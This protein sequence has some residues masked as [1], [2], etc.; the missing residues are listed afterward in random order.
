LTRVAVVVEQPAFRAGLE[1]M[2]RESGFELAPEEEAEVIISDTLE[3]AA[4][5]DNVAVVLIGDA[6]LLGEALEAGVRGV[7]PGNSTTDEL[8]AV[9]QA[10]AAGLVAFPA[11]NAAALFDARP[12]S[13]MSPADA[14]VL[15]PRELEVLQMMAEGLANKEIAWRMGISEHTV[16]FHVASILNRLDAGSRT[17][18]VSMGLRRGLIM[19]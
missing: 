13:A 16:K 1:S 7:I 3:R 18:A 9:V 2:L 5:F 19:L 8:A 12:A 11:A 10:A 4:E 15:S 17:Q 14:G 6:A